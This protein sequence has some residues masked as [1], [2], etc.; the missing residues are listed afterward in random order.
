MWLLFFLILRDTWPG[1]I[2]TSSKLSGEKHL[3]ESLSCHCWVFLPLLSPTGHLFPHLSSPAGRWSEKAQQLETAPTK[4]PEFCRSSQW[5]SLNPT[6]LSSASLRQ[7]LRPLKEGEVITRNRKNLTDIILL[8]YLQ[9]HKVVGTKR[10]KN[11]TH[12]EDLREVPLCGCSA[13]GLRSAPKDRTAEENAEGGVK[14]AQQPRSYASPVGTTQLD[15]WCEAMGTNL[16]FHG[17]LHIV[18]MLEDS[19]LGYTIGRGALLQVR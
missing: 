4:S 10:N 16:S 18:W 9:D 3:R 6:L 19:S 7:L 1:G 2:Q 17:K 5:P 13:W 14:W 8:L 12:V 15:P 11:I